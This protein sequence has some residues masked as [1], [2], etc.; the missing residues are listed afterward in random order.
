MMTE[1]DSVHQV[2]FLLQED[3]RRLTEQEAYSRMFGI[4]DPLLDK[5]GFKQAPTMFTIP[6]WEDALERLK[7]ENK[8]KIKIKGSYIWYK[9]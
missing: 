4:Y 6:Q 9:L 2:L 1:Q 8:V 5:E 7:A 3:Y